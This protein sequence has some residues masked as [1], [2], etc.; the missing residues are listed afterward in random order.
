MEHTLTA[1]FDGDVSA[2]HVAAGTSVALD[3]LLIEVRRREL[4][5][6]SLNEPSLNE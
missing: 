1:P 4:N 6:P 5:E 2:V 3:Q